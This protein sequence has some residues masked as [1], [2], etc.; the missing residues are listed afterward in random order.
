MIVAIVAMTVASA[1]LSQC[2]VSP[3]L[4]AIGAAGVVA[5]GVAAFGWQAPVAVAA[6]AVAFLLGARAGREVWAVERRTVADMPCDLRAALPVDWERFMFD[7]AEW[8][9][10]RGKWGRR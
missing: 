8:S 9:A 1:L 10:A 2:F 6:G 5:I 3:G 4:G 7:L